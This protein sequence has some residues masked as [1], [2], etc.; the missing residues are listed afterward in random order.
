MSPR[1]TVPHLQPN[2]LRRLS[3]FR[4][5]TL[6]E[7]DRL[8][9]IGGD[10]IYGNG[11]LLATEGTRKQRRVLY[12]VLQGE[13]QYVK[14]VRAQHANVVLTLRPG[15]VG[16]FLTFLNEEPSPV[17]VRSHGR[18]AVFEIGR[19]EFL[20]LATDHP[21]L[22]VKL[23]LV[24]LGDTVRHLDALLGRV[25]DTSAWALDLERHLRALPLLGG[26]TEAE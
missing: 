24:V 16:G 13:L 15:G 9:D 7:M 1:R 11:E 14:R 8:L 23:L 2:R 21:A 3:F 6:Q 17:S 25:A 20:G 22:A 10:K 12:V 5:F 18:T 19:R 4:E 26:D